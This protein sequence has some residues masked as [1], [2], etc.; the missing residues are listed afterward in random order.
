MHINFRQGLI[1]FQQ[2]SDTPLFLVPSNVF[3]AVDL[4]VSPTPLLITIAHGAT[5]Y[6]LRF[7]TSISSAWGPLVP[8]VN[9]YLFIDLNLI[10]GE[11]TFITSIHEPKTSYT[12][13][14][15]PLLGQSW[16]DLTNSV[17]KTWNSSKWII[18]PRLLVGVVL[19]GNVNQIVPET[20]GSSVS[21]N[22]SGHPGFLMI[23]SQLRPLRTN[24]GELLTTDSVVRVKT[25]IGTS[26]S[27]STPINGFFPVRA[28]EP[29][30]AMSLV[31]ITGEDS[32]SLASSDP[33][34]AIVKTPI[35]LV[36]YDLALNEIGDITM[37]GEIV[38][39]Q[40]AWPLE[41][42]GSQVYCGQN[43]EVS[44]TRPLG[45]LTYRVGVI[46][47]SKSIILDIKSETRIQLV[48]QNG[49]IISGV[50]PIFAV[51]GL[52]SNQET[53]TSISI[54]KA[55]SSTD[56]FMPKEFVLDIDKL[57]NDVLKTEADIIDLNL[58]DDSKSDVGHHHQ[59]N[60]VDGLQDALD[61]KSDIL[62]EHS[63]YALI[64][65]THS[66]YALV[67]HSHFISDIL[68]LQDELNSKASLVSLEEL[69]TYLNNQ[70]TG[71]NEELLLLRSDLDSK[72][73]TADLD[74]LKVNL[75]NRFSDI[76]DELLLLRSELDS[77]AS[78]SEL[79]ALRTNL[80]DQILGIIETVNTKAN[81]IH[82]HQISQV[83]GL[84]AELDN[85][86]NIDHVHA[87]G[88]LTGISDL[89]DTKADA[90]HK[91]SITDVI[92]L[93]A[94]LA[95]KVDKNSEGKFFL[96]DLD[97]VQATKFD[98][99]LLSYDR[100]KELWVGVDPISLVALIIINGIQ[101]PDIVLT[102]TD[103]PEGLNF[104]WTQFR[105]NSAFDS[106]FSSTSINSMFDVQT[107]RMEG[108][109]VIFPENGQVLMWQESTGQ[110]VNDYAKGN[111]ISV[112][113]KS[114]VVVLIT[115]D[116]L[117]PVL[118][119]PT[120]N[121]WWTTLRGQTLIQ[122]T[123]ITQLL[124]VDDTMVPLPNDVLVWN[125][126]KWI[127][128]IFE[129]APVTS[130]SGRIGDITLTTD[131]V[132]EKIGGN[133][134]NLYFTDDRLINA[135]EITSIDILSDVNTSNVVPGQY[136]KFFDGEIPS[137]MP[138]DPP[139]SL[140][141]SV[142]SKDG[143]VVL[144]ADDI[145][146]STSAKNVYFTPLRVLES[147]NNISLNALGDVD[148]INVLPGQYL[149]FDGSSWINAL[150]EGAS[151]VISVNGKV[152]EV[153][154]T[155]R[156]I[157]VPS[158]I[159]LEVGPAFFSFENVIKALATASIEDLSDIKGTTSAS[160]NDVLIFD[161]S[162]WKAGLSPA[163]PVTSVAG[164]LGDVVLNTLDVTEM[165]PNLYLTKSNFDSFFMTGRLSELADVNLS[166]SVS[167]QFLKYVIGAD[168]A[169]W[170]N[171]DPPASPVTS[172]AG[173]LGA[174]TLVT[175]DI[176]E[177]TD[178]LFCNLNTVK[179]LLNQLDITELKDVT[180]TAPSTGQ[181][182]RWNGIQWVNDTTPLSSAGIIG[183]LG[184]T[185]ANKAGDS[186]TG[187][188]SSTGLIT[189]TRLV[190][191][192]AQGQAPLTIGSTTL[193]TNLNSELLNT[194]ASTY[195]SDNF[196]VMA[197]SDETTALTA[198]TSKIT[199]RAPYNMTLYQIP[200]I[201]V[202]SASTSGLVIV[203]I[204]LA[205][206]SILGANKLSIDANEKT[207]VTAATPTSLAIAAIADDGEIT[208]DIT[209]AGNAKGLKL[210]LYYRKT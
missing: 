197:L 72:A 166:N 106:R 22:V 29:I 137:W 133:A 199:F 180:I 7:D 132:P 200:R 122:N 105:F 169:F 8:G 67:G 154:L 53:I 152:G 104:Y 181:V 158:D 183:A 165:T 1:S 145:E 130:V 34:L 40:W 48:S 15:S 87:A 196:M 162:F 26:G 150:A 14:S 172:V 114:D 126:S 108:S 93:E 153:I 102:T 90:I 147:L 179:A 61:H 35:G 207:S 78:S 51:T 194:K 97:D 101:G 88:D 206:V 148:I 50:E 9:N 57:K 83:V 74:A 116:I 141:V 54:V 156:D 27:L 188:I 10:S 174:V 171:A 37:S 134:L 21:L 170:I 144:T 118:Q 198:G 73:S 99:H 109:T 71:I 107:E 41:S 17:M 31:Y 2:S 167:G 12:E 70:L 59:I 182:L 185:P 155:T 140:V 43:G 94:T 161:G 173:K 129:G 210:I 32:V 28:S 81:L 184:Y 79:E 39:D 157:V 95:N 123:S 127:N 203:D 175:N 202:A 100:I 60:E 49:S 20:V 58:L 68:G 19:S 98:K 84:Q 117:E 201:S 13:P 128:R 163:A 125:G 96:N 3:G 69:R 135:L 176:I 45:I 192:I 4:S 77:K 191:T 151:P 209:S 142:N 110:W 56:G 193:V 47:N 6:L 65:H 115:D 38:Y 91:H 168:G 89:L 143:I 160:I 113:T 195:Y 11:A 204:K 103:V 75:N 139:A 62:H 187:A 177:S 18:S 36:Q 131:D 208:V 23:D 149:K 178:R 112:N 120:T 42:I 186:F 5:D 92:N 85:K 44:L 159:D 30:P 55:D 121:L 25:T 52:N 146:E 189:G 33:S 138:A 136:L 86:S 63:N 124:D 205:G 164:K 24:S 46:K 76:T 16:F 64:D 82:N 66:I 119:T 80:N 190:S 111:V